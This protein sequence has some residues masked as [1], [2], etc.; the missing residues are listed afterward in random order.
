VLAIVAIAVLLLGSISSGSDTPQVQR[1][2]VTV[3][4]RPLA[5]VRPVPG[6]FLGL[7]LEY[8]AV[9]DYAGSDPAAI[10][11]LFVRLVRALAPGQSPVLRIGGDSADWTW[12]PIAGAARPP[13]VTYTLTPRWIAVARAVAQALDARLVLG[14]NLEADSTAVA[15]AEALALVAGLGRD[16]VQTLELGNEPEL[17]GSFP[18]YRTPQGRKVNGRPASYDFSAFL[19]DFTRFAAALWPIPVAGPTVTG[20]GWMS[21]L[22]QFLSAE[23]R[24]GL[25]T[26]HRYPLQLCFVSR[27]SPRYPTIG[28]LLAASASTGLAQTFKPFVQIA[29]AHGLFL[30]IDEL[31]TVSCGS[32]RAVS[33]TFA[34]ALWVLDTLFEMVRAGVDGVNIHTFP[35]AGYELFHFSRVD[36]HWQASVAPEYY[37]LLAFAQATPPGAELLG[38]SGDHAP[39]KVWATLAPDHRLRVVV[40]NK[41]SSRRLVATL[42]LPAHGPAIVEQ[43]R[44]PSASART[45]VT[46]PHTSV[47]SA[48][49]SYVM[50]LPAASAAVLTVA[51][52]LP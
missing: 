45:G 8:A 7:S 2:D 49:G 30:R 19:G 25:V 10:N 4:P 50:A 36:G 38:V 11:P 41:S 21:R 44:A 15:R 29:R 9:E 20:P 37:G 34:S 47:S 18:W 35:G 48:T 42:R 6:G 14:V 12:W 40:I 26:L 17:Y 5:A 1:A 52:P 39:I 24:V 31:N 46:L 43:L 28:H 32:D 23:P 3:S 51:D 13:G 27:S 16:R 33:Q 22:S